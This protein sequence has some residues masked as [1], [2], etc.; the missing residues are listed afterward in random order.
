M[1]GGQMAR[2]DTPGFHRYQD[3]NPNTRVDRMCFLQK[4]WLCKFLV[5]KKGEKDDE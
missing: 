1:A 3:K 2:R 4:N 5:V